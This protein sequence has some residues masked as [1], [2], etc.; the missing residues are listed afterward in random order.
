MNHP[1]LRKAAWVFLTAGLVF[2]GFGVAGWHLPIP[3]PKGWEH[4]VSAAY[5]VVGVYLLSMALAIWI[6][7]R[8]NRTG[9]NQHG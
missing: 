9:P 6:L 3:E 2:G 8:S 5:A 1:G 7:V 4:P